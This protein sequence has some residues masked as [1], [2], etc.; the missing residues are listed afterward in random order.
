VGEQN[1]IRRPLPL[2]A[3]AERD[4][5]R[6]TKLLAAAEHLSCEDTP[7]DFGKADASAAFSPIDDLRDHCDG[8]YLKPLRSVIRSIRSDE[9][10]VHALDDRDVARLSE[11]VDR[12]VEGMSAALEPVWRS[13]GSVTMRRWRGADAIEA[14]TRALKDQC[15]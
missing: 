14:L 6:W 5:T 13:D 10:L 1:S 2:S 9:T 11:M 7:V 3:H 12:A 8:E 4:R 15:L